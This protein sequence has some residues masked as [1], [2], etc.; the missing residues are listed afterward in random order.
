MIYILDMEYLQSGMVHLDLEIC[1]V[2]LSTSRQIIG[3]KSYGRVVLESD[4]IILNEMFQI[5]IF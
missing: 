4:L 2:D 1:P 3:Y 5:F